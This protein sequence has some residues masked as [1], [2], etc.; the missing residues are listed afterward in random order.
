MEIIVEDQD[1]TEEDFDVGTEFN[2]PAP[3]AE[4]AIPDAVIPDVLPGVGDDDITTYKTIEAGTRR[5]RVIL[6]DSHGYSYTKKWKKAGSTSSKVTWLCSIRNKFQ[7]C[8]VSVHQDGDSFKT[9]LHTEHSH[10][11]RPG[12]EVAVAVKSLVKARAKAEVFKSAGAIVEEVIS[13]E[14]DPDG[15]AAC[16]PDPVYLARAANRH[17]QSQRP[18][19]PRDLDFVLDQGFI[20]DG[21]L[22]KD[23][24]LDGARHVLLF[25]AEQLELLDKAK[26]WYLDGTF[27]LVKQPF[28]QLFSVHAFV[29]SDSG[30]QKQVPLAFVMMSR[31]TK[32]DYRKVLK[33]LKRK[34]PS[35]AANLQEVVLDFEIGLW[36]AIRT[37]FPYVSPKGCL[38]HWT[39]AVWRKCQAL[40]LAVPYTTD[41]GV[42]DFIG[43][44]LSLP[45]LPHEHIGPTFEALNN[46][47]RGQE[48]ITALCDYVRNTWLEGS[49]WSPSD[50]SVFMRS[51][52][53]NNDVE[54]WHR[55]INGRAGRHTVQFYNVVKLLHAESRFVQIQVKLV[56][57]A[58]LCRNQRRM[59]HQIQGRVFKLWD[60]YR[61]GTI[62]TTALLAA[63]KHLTGPSL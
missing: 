53:T 39:Q 17:R 26:T 7:R 40:G 2:V 59:Y 50:W 44:L 56:K 42:R 25:T 15:P 14:I 47:A 19:E 36:G 18:P 63:C 46:R 12:T 24:R 60:D 13:T 6:V 52:R 48:I 30:G 4:E 28:V 27:K 5:G 21:F 51:V 16:C 43:Q 33:A 38:F 20:P 1:L 11:A 57:E 22:Q 58:R 29:K 3:P 10:P 35:A 37:V 32:R 62:S 55:R 31:R 8:A 9:G 54:G 49:T 34:L 23:I 41:E 45:F 61:A